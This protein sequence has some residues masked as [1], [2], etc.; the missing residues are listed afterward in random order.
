MVARFTKSKQ[1][2]SHLACFSSVYVLHFK[3]N[4]CLR[5]HFNRHPGWIGLIADA[6]DNRP[7]R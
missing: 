3:L 4:R 6:T 7:M 2:H 5:V 1:N